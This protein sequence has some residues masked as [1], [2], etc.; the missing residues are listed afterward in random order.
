MQAVSNVVVK[1]SES[2]SAPPENMPNLLAHL[3]HF[4]FG[5]IRNF[6]AIH[7]TCPASGFSR[8]S[9]ILIIVD[10]PPPEL[11]ELSWFH[12]HHF[13]AQPVQH[14]AFVKR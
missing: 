6:F 13:K 3:H 5:V 8:P 12:P 7:K 2:N 10:L 4:D 1:E 14:S 9:T 11:P